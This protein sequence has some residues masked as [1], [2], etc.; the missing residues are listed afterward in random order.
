MLLFLMIAPAT[1]GESTSLD[2]RVVMVL[3]WLPANTQSMVVTDLANTDLFTDRVLFP[4]TESGMG[5]QLPYLRPI[6]ALDGVISSGK[7]ILC[8]D[9][10]FADAERN[11]EGG[12]PSCHFLYLSGDDN[13][14]QS[15]LEDLKKHAVRTYMDSGQIVTEFGRGGIKTEKVVY[16]MCMPKPGLVIGATTSGAMHQVLERM[17]PESKSRVALPEA[18]IEWTNLNVNSPCW[19]LRHFAEDDPI[20]PRALLDARKLDP[21]AVGINFSYDAG[22]RCTIVNYFSSNPEIKRIATAI[23]AIDDRSMKWQ[24]VTY[25]QPK[26]GIFTMRI[27]NEKNHFPHVLWTSISYWFGEATIPDNMLESVFERFDKSR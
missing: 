7:P 24:P 22:Q 12:N 18:L 10:T 13:L 20:S 14:Y 11:A 3:K 16:R 1:N 23:A 9:C 4:M 8:I 27:S 26:D 15:Q 25:S 21:K 6:W 19:G 2:P 17:Q 5:W